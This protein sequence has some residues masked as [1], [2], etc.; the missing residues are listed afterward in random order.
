MPSSKALYIAL[1]VSKIDNNATTLVGT[2]DIDVL[3][4]GHGDDRL[5][6][7]G[8]TD[9]YRYSFGDGADTISDLENNAF[10]ND[11]DMLQFLHGIMISDVLFII[12][13]HFASLLQPRLEI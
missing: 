12:K 11:N 8:D 2:E 5:V 4:G 9:I 7:G 1:A 3:Q 10:R 6:G 13:F